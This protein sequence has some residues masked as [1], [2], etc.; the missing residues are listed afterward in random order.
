MG[1]LKISEN[2][3]EKEVLKSEGKVVVDFYAD[4][5]SPCKMLAPVME[6]I[7]EEVD[8]KTKFVKVNIDEN[9]SIAEKYEIM[10][11][12]T[13]IIFENGSIKNTI[14]GLR[15]KQEMIDAINA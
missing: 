3:F 9:M 4:W 15:S 12:P 7:S 11:I 2:D 8:T 13:V 5:C 6:K 10:S 1:V 14:I